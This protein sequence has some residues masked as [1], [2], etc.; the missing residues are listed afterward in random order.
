[1][2]NV[3]FLPY[4]CKKLETMALRKIIHVEMREPVNGERH[5]YF[6]SKA[7][8]FQQFTPEQLGITYYTLKNVSIVEGKPYINKNC[9]IRQGKL[10][11]SNGK[12]K[13][14]S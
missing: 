4:L 14:E 9:I 12:E 13:E 2:A 11:A 10:I 7:A 1:M 6:G 5:F 8:I 3:E